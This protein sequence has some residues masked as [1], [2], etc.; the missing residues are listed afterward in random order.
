MKKKKK[1][2]KAFRETKKETILAEKRINIKYTVF[3]RT[4]V[5]FNY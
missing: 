5:Y 2:V 3:Q 4:R 1:K